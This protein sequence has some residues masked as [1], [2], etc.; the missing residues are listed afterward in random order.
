MMQN[1][2]SED[3]K[4]LSYKLIFILM[5]VA[6][7]F[8]FALRMIWVYQFQGNP[9]Y[10]WNGELM[11]NT[12]D[13]YYFAS[14]A[15]KWLE[16]T[17][18]HN[19]QVKDV[20]YTAA[21]TLTAFAAKYLP[22][23]LDTV[24][25]YMPAVVSS[26]VVVPVILIGRLFNMTSVGFFAA[27]LG[28][29]AW[30]YYNRTMT[31]YFDTDMFS[32]MAPMFILYFLLATLKSEKPVY[33]LLAA[34]SVLIYPFLYDHGQAIVYSMGVLYMVYMVVF[35]RRDPFTYTSILLVSIGLMQVDFW[36]QFVLIIAV[37]AAMKKNMLKKSV[38][39]Y[40]AFGAVLVFLYTGHVFGLILGK[41]MLYLN[42]GVDQSGGLHYFQVIQTVRE[43]GK[44]PFSVMADRISGSVPGVLVALAGYIV[45]VM[46]QKEFI[47]ALPLIGIGVFSLWGGL[48]FTVY[49]V[50]VAAIGAVYFFYVAAAYL[51]NKAARI[52]LIGA[53][54][55]AMLYPNITHIIGYKVPTVFN[56]EEV[57]A[58]KRLS[59]MGNDKDYVIAWWDY[60]YPIWYY[61][62]K[63]TLI[64]GGKHE[65]DNF[66]VSEILTTGSSQEAARLGRIAVETYVDS[67]YKKVADTLF[68]NK[69]PDQLD[70]NAYLETLKYGEMQ[71][72]EATRNVY[73]FLP[74]RMMDIFPTVTVFSNLDLNTGHEYQRPFF[75]PTTRYKEANGLL[76]LG[77]GVLVDMRSGQVRIGDKEMPLRAFYRANLRKDGSVKT[78]YQLINMN[79]GLSLVYMASYGE[80]LLLDDAMLNSMYIQMFVFGKYDD[81]LFE[82][83][84]SDPWVRVYKLKI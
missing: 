36:L 20:Y 63:N 58:L 25:L 17:L 24:I 40:M 35:H 60:G 23:S 62:N 6:Y 61:G 28:S 56:S 19:P 75:Y 78:D 30:S 16:G 79:G 66:I 41:V 13:G 51:E 83:V 12:N 18:Q 8:S 84:I 44:I 82:P 77:Q 5:I 11:I 71:M 3:D 4:A 68:K 72:P 9:Q 7:A 34:L 80:F 21:I 49:A 74:F 26:L 39:V 33:A 52:G 67:G 32:A 47:L 43:A 37:F 14:A 48:R 42:R 76:N 54:T 55:A 38:T 70:P 22:F 27:L 10:M 64:D 81:K 50:P 15:Q 65:Q 73:L 69:Q 57:G 31:G 1:I 59:K 2:F 29:V 45:L 46:R 53:M